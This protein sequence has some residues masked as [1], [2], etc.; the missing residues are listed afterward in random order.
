MARVA[1]K[2]LGG[3]L[4]GRREVLVWQAWHLQSGPCS[5]VTHDAQRAICEAGMALAALRWM[6]W[7]ALVA[8]T[9]RRFPNGKELLHGWRRGLLGGLGCWCFRCSRNFCGAGV[10]R[11]LAT[12]WRF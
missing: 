3:L 8:V 6:G 1:F 5:F 4:C 11:L 7:T 12:P 10:L 9:S 2:A